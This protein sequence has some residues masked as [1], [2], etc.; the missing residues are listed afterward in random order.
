MKR[1]TK[2][3]SV[4]GDQVHIGDKGTQIQY[5]TVGE[6]K[7]PQQ[8]FSEI[9]QSIE[10]SELSH[11]IK[12][13]LISDVNAL[14]SGDLNRIAAAQMTDNIL[15]QAPSLREKFEDFVL[16][17]GSSL[18]ATGV[19]EHGDKIIAGMKFALGLL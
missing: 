16:G 3:G 12:T 6:G 17:V 15:N 1:E 18:T 9:R 13:A 10:K 5:K 4:H 2:I 14:E 7:T 19:W 11:D 8:F